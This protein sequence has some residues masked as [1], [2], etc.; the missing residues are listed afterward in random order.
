MAEK[1]NWL[2]ILVLVFGMMFVSCVTTH[3]EHLAQFTVV[4]TM[5]VDLSRIGDFNRTA[6]PVTGESREFQNFFMKWRG[7]SD[8]RL[9]RAMDNAIR[10]VPGGVAIIDV[11]VEQSSVTRG[12]RNRQD[13]RVI[14][15]GVVLVDPRIIT[16]IESDKPIIS[17][18]TIDGDIIAIAPITSEDLC[19]ILDN[20]LHILSSMAR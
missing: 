14:V 11:R 18:Q 10:S 12:I 17:V 20:P 19:F 13:N 6:Q 2:G 9:E 16:S 15:S 7:D 8:R 1:R 4:S 5:T 3:V